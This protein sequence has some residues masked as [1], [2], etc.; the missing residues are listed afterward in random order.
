MRRSIKISCFIW[1]YHYNP[2]QVLNFL[3]LMA[4]CMW[5]LFLSL[6]VPRF[7]LQVFHFYLFSDNY[8]I[9]PSCSILVFPFIFLWDYLV[10]W[11]SGGLLF[12]KECNLFSHLESYVPENL[13]VQDELLLHRDQVDPEQL[14]HSVSLAEP[15]GSIS[16]RSPS[17]F[18]EPLT[19]H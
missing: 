10:N 19:T 16:V 2:T 14:L 7:L 13:D 11:N 17:D 9:K 1:S 5:S 3:P 4:H 8:L 15:S 18:S 6:S 12:L